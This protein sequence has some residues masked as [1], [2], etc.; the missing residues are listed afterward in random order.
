MKELKLREGWLSLLLLL[1]LGL[2]LAW[3][4][5]ANE[6][7]PGIWVLQWI[8]IVGTLVGVA[9]ARVRLPGALAHLI[10]IAV[11]VAFG[12]FLTATLMP[13][14]MPWEE[15]LDGLLMRLADWWLQATGA[16]ESY[17]T[18]MFI[19]FTTL[20]FWVFSYIAA[21]SIFRAH[22]VWGAILP[23]GTVI[24]MNTYYN[25]KLMPYFVSY[26]LLSLLL[27][28]RFT[29]FEREEEWQRENVRYNADF[30][31]DFLQNGAISSVLI[32]AAAWLIPLTVTNP[33]EWPVWQ[34][35]EDPWQEVQFH[36]NRVF[37][38]VSGAGGSGRFNFFTKTM[39]LGGPV[40][41]GNSIVMEVKANEPQ[42]WRAQV[43]DEYIGGGWRNT[44]PDEIEL[45]ANATV[46]RPMPYAERVELT[47][48]V[49]IYVSGEKMIFAANQ[50][51]QVNK[52]STARVNYLQP[53]IRQGTTAPI[54]G[55]VAE[56]STLASKLRMRRYEIYQATSL[57]SNAGSSKLRQAGTAYPDWVRA[58]YLQLPSTLTQRVRDLAQ[59]ITAGKI[60]PYDKAI[61]IE[62]YLRQIPYDETVA[63]PP[64]GTDPVHWFL[65]DERRGYCDYYSSAMAVLLRAVGVPA[66]VARGYA[67]GEYNAGVG[68]YV[69]RELDAHAWPEVFFPTYGWIDFEPTAAQPA[70]S[71]LLTEEDIAEEEAASPAAALT[72]GAPS[73]NILEEGEEDFQ[74]GGGQFPFERTPWWY[75]SELIGAGW[76][77]RIGVALGIVALYYL[78]R[79]ILKRRR[80]DMTLT[81]FAFDDMVKY[82]RW[83]GIHLQT[84]QTP[85]E[86]AD[87]FVKVVEEGQAETRMIADLYVREH[88]AKQPVTVYEEMT[89]MDAWRKMR[90]AAWVYLLIKY[91]PL[92][93][94]TAQSLR[95]AVRS[96]ASS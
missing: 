68:S 70:L 95:S 64:D 28:V 76:L 31:F 2:C 78:I 59:Q 94:E 93:K 4:L 50:V 25:P 7:A 36:W 48:T 12:G 14:S 26:L 3:A 29:L 18:L 75:P 49:K 23:N 30:I 34:N 63:G 35:F 61:A 83:L 39:T 66:R 62:Q 41:L 45:T 1:A 21:Y 56:I 9:L 96:S 19:L 43:F 87:A 57:I 89:A 47:Q 86:C 20:L 77:T 52:D 10:G 27:I 91:L 85:Y 38:S 55:P 69:V 40:S 37:A 90:E 67:Q 16:G 53:I 60:T 79:F 6:L 11:G 46:P 5:Q 13:A 44:D 71:H 74:G 72:P 22:W 17:D 88:Y 51:T 84:S 15:R 8:V 54:A 92:R 42:H 73:R 65:F 24:L 81:T 58:K 80:G 82:A 33:K 32:I